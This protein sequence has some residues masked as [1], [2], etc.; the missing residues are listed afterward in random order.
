MHKSLMTCSAFQRCVLPTP[1]LLVWLFLIVNLLRSALAVCALAYIH[2]LH[3]VRLT[4]CRKICLVPPVNRMALCAS[5]QTSVGF[6]AMLQGAH[7]GEGVRHWSA[8]DIGTAAVPLWMLL[9]GF[10]R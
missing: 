7:L 1:G 6:D 4:T 3:G 5:D 10:P 9:A 2:S 8:S